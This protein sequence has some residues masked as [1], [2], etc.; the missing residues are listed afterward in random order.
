MKKIKYLCL[1]FLSTCAFAQVA[2]GKSTISSP[3]V[4]LEFGTENRG[5]V[6]PWVSTIANQPTANYTAISGTEDGT[7][8]F[9]LSDYKVKYRKAG[10]WFDLTVKNKTDVISGITNNTVNSSIQDTKKELQNAKTMIGGN[11]STDT[12]KGIL[13]LADTNK[14][15]ILPLVENPHS[16]I[17][18]PAAGMVVYD[19]TNNLFCVYNGTVWSFWKP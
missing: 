19:P 2:I 10:A 9:D 1:I 14:A 17:N 3:A 7:L 18:N 11:P 12:T 5:I 16:T 4:S 15:M 6:L 8:I 13:V